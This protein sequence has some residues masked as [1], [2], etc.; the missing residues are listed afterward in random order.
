MTDLE[1]IELK[2]FLIAKSDLFAMNASEMGC[3]D[4]LKHRIELEDSTPFKEKFRPIPPGSYDE[5]R[6]HLAELLSVG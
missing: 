5:V 6:K 1:V 3:T 4:V 2:A